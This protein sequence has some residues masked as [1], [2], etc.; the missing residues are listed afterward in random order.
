MLDPQAKA[1]LDL[2][3]SRDLPSYHTLPPPQARHLYREARFFSQPAPIEMAEIRM[4]AAP[5]RRGDIPIRSYLPHGIDA[6]GPVPALVFLHGGGFVIG[7]LDTHDV[8][9]REL[10]DK[11]RCRVMSVDYRLAPEHRFPAALE[12]AVAAV[13][14]VSSRA[15]TLGIDARRIAVGGDS[16]GGNLAASACL[17]LR[18]AG[19]ALPCLQLL[20]Y[21]GTD[22]RGVSESHRTRGEGFLLTR[23]LIDWFSECYVGWPA[24]RLDPRA[25]PLLARDH[26]GLPAAYVLTAEYDPLRDEGRD[27]AR[28]LAAAGVPT[29]HEDVPG[30]VHGFITMGRVMDAANASVARCAQVLREAFGRAP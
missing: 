9:C 12:D 6:A 1:L 14:W 15:G 22:L 5:G 25:S 30:Q 24:Q 27:Y 20:I 7:D 13:R 10:A 29:I 18:D 28:A 4:H 3:A 8:L 11:A 26:A 2:V 21:P 23:A 19:D 16:A 17:T